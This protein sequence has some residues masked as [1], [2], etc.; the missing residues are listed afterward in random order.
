MLLATVS[1][2]CTETMSTTP[3]EKKKNRSSPRRVVVADDDGSSSPFLDHAK[4]VVSAAAASAQQHGVDILASAALSH[5]EDAHAP[6]GV[7]KVA[8]MKGTAGSR[9]SLGSSKSPS[10]KKKPPTSSSSHRKKVRKSNGGSSKNNKKDDH[11]QQASTIKTATTNHSEEGEDSSEQGTSSFTSKDV[12]SGRGGATNLHP[13]NRYYRDLILKHRQV[14]DLA[15]K[16]RK[17]GTYVHTTYC[18]C[19][20][21]PQTDAC[22]YLCLTTFKSILFVFHSV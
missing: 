14:Y 5:S 3:T 20:C 1:T 2:I 18:S 19:C 17:P 6:G 7:G 13:G 4:V 21:N 8:K 16:G 12:L 10:K 11:H 15:S 22:M 9:S